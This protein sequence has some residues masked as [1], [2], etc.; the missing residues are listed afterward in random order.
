MAKTKSA[1]S[2]TPLGDRV[3]VQPTKVDEKT[4]SGIIIPGSANT[5]KQ[6]QGTIIAIG[7]LEH[8]TNV[9][10]GDTVLFGYSYEIAKEGK[11]EYYLI[12]SKDL[13]GKIA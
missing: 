5:E 9:A 7:D 3:L 13:F 11:E 8:T 2:I 1:P 6:N 10:I 4:A 12:E